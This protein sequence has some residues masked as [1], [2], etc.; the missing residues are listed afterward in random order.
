MVL[1]AGD[2]GPAGGAGPEPVGVLAGT[3]ELR[4]DLDPP[5][6]GELAVPAVGVL[7]DGGAGDGD[8]DGVPPDGGDP[9]ADGLPP[10]DGCPV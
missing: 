6:D 3:P 2:P 10:C 9:D 8:A 4:A 1:V 7:P 5:D